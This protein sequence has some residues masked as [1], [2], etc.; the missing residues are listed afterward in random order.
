MKSKFDSDN[1]LPL[2]KT[3][4]SSIVTIGIKAVFLENNKYCPQFF[5][6]NVYVKYKNDIL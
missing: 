4:E 6:I 3:I 1:N 5:Q 2:D